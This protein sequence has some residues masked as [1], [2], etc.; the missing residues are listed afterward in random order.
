[1]ND[2]TQVFFTVLPMLIA[3]AV[4]LGSADAAMAEIQARRLMARRMRRHNGG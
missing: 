2:I 1:M 4:L 3:A